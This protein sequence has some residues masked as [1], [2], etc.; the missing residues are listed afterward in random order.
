MLFTQAKAQTISGNFEKKPD[1]YNAEILDKAQYSIHYQFHFLEKVDEKDSFEKGFVTLQLG[2]KIV[3]FTDFYGLKNDSIAEVH[4]HLNSI[5]A[6]EFNERLSIFKEIKFEKNIFTNITDNKILFQSNVVP[7][8]NYEY[9]L[10]IPK[11]EW[12]IEQEINEIL[13]Y[14][15]QKATVAYGGRNW[16]AWFTPEIPIQYGPYVF[17][18]LPGL[19]VKLHDDKNNFTFLLNAID[20]TE[21]DIYKRIYDNVTKTTKEKY[22]KVEKDFHDRPDMYFDSSA[23]RGGKG[24]S[25]S[26][27]L[28]Y[29]PIEVN[30]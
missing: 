4:S 27:K 12:K 9:E 19:I 25:S 22:M 3:K 6:K 11:L 21:T 15:V 1:A 8:F 17:N 28:P 2:T 10:E 29:N 7:R 26:D 5:K 16:I 30:D 14:N 23:I 20:K 18:G 24:F 13:G